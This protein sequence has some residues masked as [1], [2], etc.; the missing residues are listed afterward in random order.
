MKEDDFNK[1]SHLCRIF[2]TE[3]EKK[4][5]LK[6]LDNVLIYIEQLQEVDTEGVE[7]CYTV[8]ETLPNVMREDLP[9]APLSRDL[10]LANAPAQVGGMVKV[11]PVLKQ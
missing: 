5:F 2:C 10:F 7:A 6:S 4:A 11:P 3:E 1:L 9:E 8:L